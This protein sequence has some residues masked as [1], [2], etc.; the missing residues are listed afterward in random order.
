MKYLT[1]VTWQKESAH[2]RKSAD[3]ELQ[4]KLIVAF[5]KNNNDIM[6]KIENALKSDDIK[7]AH[8]LTHTLKGNAGQLGKTQL[9][10][11][12]ENVE[13]LLAKGKNLVVPELMAALD[14]ELK[15][16]LNEFTAETKYSKEYT[17]ESEELMDSK[18]V[19]ELFAELEPLLGSSDAE[20]VSYVN[21]LNNIGGTEKL[22]GLIDSFEFEPALEELIRLRK[23]M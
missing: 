14:K 7:L 1:P 13:N 23:E 6:E 12:A 3:T 5:V 21:K 4:N 8:R 19:L 9:Q 22:I 18:A 20:C 10:D 2:K 17:R 15:A 11:I 16:V